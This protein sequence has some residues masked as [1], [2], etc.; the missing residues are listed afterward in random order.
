MTPLLCAC[1]VVITLET[2][3][4]RKKA[5]RLVEFNFFMNCNRR[6]R[7]SQNK[8][9][10]ADLQNIASK[11]LIFAWALSY[12]LSKFSIEI[13]PFFRLWKIIIKGVLPVGFNAPSINNYCCSNDD[14][15][16][17]MKLLVT[18]KRS[19]S[20]CL[21]TRRALCWE[22]DPESVSAL[23]WWIFPVESMVKVQCWISNCNTVK[24]KAKKWHVQAVV[25]S[26]LSSSNHATS[27]KGFEMFGTSRNQFVGNLS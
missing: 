17:S 24:R 25:T 2:Q 4:C 6:K 8:R 23:I 1:A 11:F 16:T 15:S 3:K 22:K 21:S 19:R 27:C 10:R 18:T 26:V 20:L 14:R 13:S 5:P 7:F 9:R 12:D